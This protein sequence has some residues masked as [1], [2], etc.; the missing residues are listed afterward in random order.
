MVLTAT[1][2][3]LAR[4]CHPEPTLAVTAGAA[5]LAVAMHR[6]LRGVVLVG[7]TVL[8]S[9]L[10]V[11]WHNDW[12]DA[13]RDARTGRPDKPIPAGAIARRSV[14]V[15]AL[16]AG[17]ATVALSPLSGPAGA[18]VA[19]TG[20]AAA[21]V[22]NWPVKATVLSVVPYAVSFAALPVFVLVG[23]PGAG[24]P[25]AWLVAAGALLGAGAHFAN[26]LPDLDDDVRTGVRGLP[27]RIG[28]T[29]S[30]VLAG[31]LLV[32]ASLL[33]VTGPPGPPT[34]VAT[35]G[36]LA[37]GAV[38]VAGGYAGLRGRPGS[39]VLFRAAMVAALI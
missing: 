8:A 19:L 37:A 30:A 26:A 22:Y 21:L 34:P 33:I 29:P 25:P 17:L 10:A 2:G 14:G 9:Q 36:G 39:R 4:A 13:D 12:V 5:T 24:P 7:A 38:L 35:V 31:L 23:R 11:G 15:A 6:D 28:A 32:T 27:H 1:V 3:G 16:A 18:L 20:L